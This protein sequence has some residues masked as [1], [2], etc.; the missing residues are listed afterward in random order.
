MSPVKDKQSDASPFFGIVFAPIPNPTMKSDKW[1]Y[2]FT[3]A[4]ITS[5]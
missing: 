4:S 3:N 2:P 1:R 5:L